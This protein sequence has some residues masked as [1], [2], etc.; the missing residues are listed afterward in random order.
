MQKLVDRDAPEFE[1]LLVEFRQKIA[2]LRMR[3]EPLIERIRSKK[4][5]TSAGVSLLEVKAHSLLSY[6]TNLAFLLL[7]KLHGKS[8]AS[9]SAIDRLVELRIVMEKIRPLEQKLK[10]QIDK[11]VKAAESGSGDASAAAGD[12]A[13]FADPLR[14]KPNPANLVGKEVEDADSAEPGSGVYRPPK[15][16][17]MPYIEP[18][19]GPKGGRLSARA[20]ESAS[21]S[22]LLADLRT[23]FDDRPEE[24]SAEGTGYGAREV[25]GG[26]ADDE[27]WAERERFEEENMI[28]LSMTREDKRSQKRMAKM[29]GLKR[30]Q[31]EFDTLET[32]FSSLHGLSRAVKEDD[33]A[34]YGEGV[35]RKKEKLSAKFT[36]QK[37]KFGDAGEMLASLA[38]GERSRGKD[39]FGREVKKVKA[40]ARR[41]AA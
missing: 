27:R 35:L 25:I 18:T 13:V 36:S 33:R 3:V 16:A 4:L 1:S 32:D 23:Q 28:R 8:I 7:V 11:L 22:R 17:P 10:Y 21:R 29:G 9:H 6:I 12:E 30:F 34:A 24:M 14:F 2:E 38:R 40:K 41:K 5:Q 39:E 26:N 15:L 20:L 37:R 19:R 31:D